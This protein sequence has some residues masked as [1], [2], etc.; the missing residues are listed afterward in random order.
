M[1]EKK[2]IKQL[3]HKTHF[4]HAIFKGSLVALGILIFSL[5]F[6]IAGYC[7]YFDFGFVDGLINASMILAGMGPVDMARTDS[8]K[9]FASI[10]AIYSGVAF[11]SM[12]AVI[13]GPILHRFLHR[14]H[15]DLEE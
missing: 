13:S 10:Y 7:Y 2:R 1:A 8:A 9:I 4:Y 5:S 11:L 12:L 6:G 3:P 15:L 14:F